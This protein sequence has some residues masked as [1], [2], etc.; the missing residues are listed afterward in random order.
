MS[1]LHDKDDSTIFSWVPSWLKNV[2]TPCVAIGCGIAGVLAFNWTYDQLKRKWNN[3]PPG[4]TGFPLIG[5]V[6]SMMKDER[7]YFLELND[8]YKYISM[9]YMFRQPIVCIHD[10]RIMK[11]YFKKEQ[12]SD[13]PQSKI[14][15][16]NSFLNLNWKQIEL[17]RKILIHSLV[18]QAQRSNKLYQLIGDNIIKNTVFKQIE[19]CIQSNTKWNIRKEARFVTFSTIYGLF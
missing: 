18:S 12:F 13:R 10:S 1:G 15:L 16:I 9:Y 7:K 8:E 5:S 2:G 11:E 19:N 14:F 3:Y 17:R 4:P 6:L